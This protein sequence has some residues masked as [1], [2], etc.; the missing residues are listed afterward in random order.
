MKVYLINLD[1][2]PERLAW[3]MGQVEGKGVDVVRVPAVDAR[4]L[5]D[6]EFERLLKL[7]SGH[8]SMSP[9]EMGCLLSHRKVWQLVA[10]GPEEW[11]FI[12]ED[13]IHLSAE[14]PKFLSDDSWIPP[15]ADI[16]RAETD[17]RIQEMSYELVGTAS[18]R[19]LRAL[20]SKQLGS[21]GYFICRSASDK[22]I[23]HT[24][25]HVEPVDVV[26]FALHAGLLRELRV[27]QLV[28]ALCVQ[29]MWHPDSVPNATLVS[30]IA[31]GRLE[32]HRGDNRSARRRGRAK[33]SYETQRVFW[34]L[35]EM[36]KR[37]LFGL[38]RI[39]IWTKV[40]YR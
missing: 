19:Q 8:N 24:N 20:K 9:A 2:S 36:C 7:T 32:F 39:S 21:A 3:F 1:R 26:L 12:A 30:Q 5:P 11:A 23:S 38:C 10:D 16:V 18:G 13:D 35:Y 33:L 27:L 34:Q 40:Q 22:L 29:D 14:A 6:D 4:G 37:P 17:M 31:V 25:T 28:P 15:G